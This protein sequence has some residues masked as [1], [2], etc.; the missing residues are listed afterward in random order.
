M[1]EGEEALV[2]L[3]RAM[4]RGEEGR[5]VEGIW[6]REGGGIRQNSVRPFL[7]DLD[8]LPFPDY[9]METQFALMDGRGESLGAALKDLLWGRRP[10]SEEPEPSSDLLPPHMQ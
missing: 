9:D 2:E 6:F 4:E 8:G 10:R 7:Q 1:G 5:D 3:V